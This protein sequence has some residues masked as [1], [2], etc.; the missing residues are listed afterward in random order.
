M[1]NNHRTVI[2]IDDEPALLY[3]NRV[4]L[5]GEGYRVLEAK[6]GNKAL[7][8][9]KTFP[10]DIDAAILDIELPDMDG[11]T[12]CKQIRE[13]RP[14]LKVIMCSGYLV[15]GSVQ[16]KMHEEASGFMEKPYGLSTLLWTLKEVL[17]EG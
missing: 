8:I 12:V 13:L 10:G 3:V 11:E 7:E 6:T 16:A 2:L 4:I 15:D 5:E 9:V 1:A 14:N 17:E